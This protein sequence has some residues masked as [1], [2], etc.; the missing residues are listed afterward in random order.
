MTTDR[1]RTLSAVARSAIGRLVDAVGGLAMT[2]SSGKGG[3]V[4]VKNSMELLRHNVRAFHNVT[5]WICVCVCVPASLS[6]YMCVRTCARCLPGPGRALDEKLS[7]RKA[8]T[9]TVP[10]KTAVFLNSAVATPAIRTVT[11]AT[12][13]SLSHFHF[14]PFHSIL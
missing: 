4:V 12:K 7:P 3:C 2:D 8:T 11:V 6:V 1:H 14:G 5:G 9:I 10:S 13:S